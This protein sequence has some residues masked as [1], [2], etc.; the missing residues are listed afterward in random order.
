MKKFAFSLSTAE[1]ILIREKVNATGTSDGVLCY[2]KN[3]F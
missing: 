3:Y 1:Q 2:I